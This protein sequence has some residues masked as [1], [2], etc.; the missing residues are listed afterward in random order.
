MTSHTSARIWFNVVTA[1]YAFWAIHRVWVEPESRT[2]WF[3]VCTFVFFSLFLLPVTLFQ[4]KIE[5]R[6]EGLHVLQYRSA[7]VPYADV[8]RCI[9]L[10]L[11]PF[12]TVIVIT[13]WKF[14]LNVLISDDTLDRT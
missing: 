14:P 9:G 12:P 5:A 11:I 4:A 1:L 7:V 10:F 6:P 2:V 13:N 3:F 8:K